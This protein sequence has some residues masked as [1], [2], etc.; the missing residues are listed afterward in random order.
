MTGNICPYAGSNCI[1]HEILSVS[2][3]IVLKGWRSNTKAA[4]VFPAAVP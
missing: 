1:V 2:A 4:W 3:A